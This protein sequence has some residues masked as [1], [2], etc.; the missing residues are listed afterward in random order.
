MHHWWRGIW[1]KGGF[2]TG[3]PISLQNHLFTA[4]TRVSSSF[5]ALDTLWCTVH[6]RGAIHHMKFTSPL[7][8]FIYLFVPSH[9]KVTP[10][11]NT[12]QTV[13]SVKQPHRCI[14]FC[15]NCQVDIVGNPPNNKFN[16]FINNNSCSKCIIYYWR[17]FP[18]QSE[19]LQQSRTAFPLRHHCLWPLSRRLSFMSCHL[20]NIMY[21]YSIIFS[22]D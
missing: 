1:K 20:V 22:I 15:F 6:W 8:L 21:Y 13:C 14:N 18:P 7:H 19:S 10:A 16:S 17:M 2:S 5:L 4:V 3:L 11:T 9:L 12:K